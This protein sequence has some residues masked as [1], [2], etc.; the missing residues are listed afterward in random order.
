[1]VALWRT[2]SGPLFV[3][4]PIPQDIVERLRETFLFWIN[5]TAMRRIESTI[6]AICNTPNM[7]YFLKNK[8]E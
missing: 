8:S 1:M 2:F 4:L 3:T 7:V 6:S 5:T